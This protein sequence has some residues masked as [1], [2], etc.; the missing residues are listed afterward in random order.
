MATKPVTSNSLVDIPLLSK[1]EKNQLEEAISLIEKTDNADFHETLLKIDEV[2][3]SAVN[4]LKTLKQLC[5]PLIKEHIFESWQEVAN[6]HKFKE[7]LVYDINFLKNYFDRLE[8]SITLGLIK[9]RYAKQKVFCIIFKTLIR[10]SD[11]TLKNYNIEILKYSSL[12]KQW[13]FRTKECDV[14]ITSA[15]IS[16]YLKKLLK[17][18][19]AGEIVKD[20][21]PSKQML[22]WEEE[23]EVTKHSESPPKITKDGKPIVELTEE[24]IT[25]H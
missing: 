12:Q 17:H 19:S 2:T 13:E 24:K 20:N 25:T 10:N 14:P 15:V 22:E 4:E 5:Q 1:L 7:L 11:G 6:L 21:I 3:K 9:P 23:N 18:E 8:K 16:G